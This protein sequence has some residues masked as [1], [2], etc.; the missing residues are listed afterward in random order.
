MQRLVPLSRRSHP[1]APR[2]PARLRAAELSIERSSAAARCWPH[3]ALWALLVLAGRRMMRRP[4]VL[5]TPLRPRCDNG[6]AGQCPLKMASMATDSRSDFVKRIS[7]HGGRLPNNP[8]LDVTS[9]PFPPLPTATN[10]ADAVYVQSWLSD[11]SLQ[12]DPTARERCVAAAFPRHS[13]NSRTHVKL[14][15][16]DRA[17][18]CALE[19][20]SPEPTTAGVAFRYGRVGTNYCSRS[21]CCL[22]HS[23][24]S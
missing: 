18:C 2:R 23:R 7:R 14:P 4:R 24:S 1:P 8:R 20:L 17:T 6:A 16:R 12:K 5:A 10:A 9:A 22:K 15:L 3:A 13:A 19:Q 11:C 21:A